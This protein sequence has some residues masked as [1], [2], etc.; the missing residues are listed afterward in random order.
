VRGFISPAE[1]IPIVEE[2]GL[3]EEL[4]AAV[5]RRACAA[6][7]NWPDGISVSVNLSSTQFRSGNLEKTILNRQPCA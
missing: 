4:G 7:A 1:F 2:I 3:M 6:C 5:L